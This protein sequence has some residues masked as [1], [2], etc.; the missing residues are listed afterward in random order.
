MFRFG[1]QHQSASQEIVDRIVVH[2]KLR[3]GEVQDTGDVDLAK[4]YDS[5]VSQ[6]QSGA[7]EETIELLK[8]EREVE[9]RRYQLRTLTA[10]ITILEQHH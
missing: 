9:V 6:L 10:W 4:K 3:S 8:V 1:E 5:A 7:R 2:L